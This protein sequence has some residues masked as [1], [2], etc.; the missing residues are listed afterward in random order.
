MENKGERMENKM[1]RKIE[2]ERKKECIKNEKENEWIEEKFHKIK[3]ER[4]RK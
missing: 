4:K 1:N 2:K 3:R